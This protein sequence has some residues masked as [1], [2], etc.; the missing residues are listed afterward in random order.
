MTTLIIAAVVGVFLPAVVAFVTKERLNNLA[1]QVILLFLSA[2][3]GVLTSIAG[4][5]PSGWH[6]W[7]QV[8]VAILVAFVAAV[9]SQFGVAE[10]HAA[11]ARKT[12]EIG[13]GP[14]K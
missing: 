12:A 5:P 6:A 14:N 8:L 1:K 10:V 9:Q 3:A 2:V 13:F 7:E 11:L 4:S